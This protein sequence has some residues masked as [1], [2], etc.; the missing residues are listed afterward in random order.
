M[1]KKKSQTGKSK[2]SNSKGKGDPY[3]I[4]PPHTQQELDA[5]DGAIGDD[6]LQDPIIIDTEGNIIDGYARRDICEER[7]IDWLAGA[8]VRVGLSHEQKLAMAIRLN[9]ARRS[10]AP[11]S[12][13][14]REYATA[15]LL[16]NAESSDS[17]IAAVIGLSRQSVQRLRSQLAKTGKL[18]PPLKTVGR[19]G[20][21]R[22]VSSEKR[23]ARFMVKSKAEYDRLA[24]VAHELQSSPKLTNGIIRRP[25][26]LPALLRREKVLAQVDK[27]RLRPLPPSI[28]I[29]CCD[30]RNLEVKPKSVDLICTD[31]VWGK[32]A[33][34][35]WADLAKLA[36]EWLKPDGMFATFIGNMHK[37]EL[38]QAVS[39]YLHPAWEFCLVFSGTTRNIARSII[40]GWRPIAVY[41]LPDSKPNFHFVKDVLTSNGPEKEYDD[42]Q[43]PLPVVKELIRRL[44]PREGTPL[45]VDPQLGT[46]TS[47]VA[48]R[49]LGVRFIGCDIDPKKI[50]IANYRIAQEGNDKQVG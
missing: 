11:T 49:Q 46:G 15:L 9:L 45:V 20:R 41:S 22:A 37:Y 39:P 30:F 43:Q 36:K 47:A 28:D 34:Q 18:T 13:Q 3:R 24:P 14:R 6:G 8:D 50:K 42:W 40:E 26:R 4:L 1:R 32:S 33:K 27:A 29:H 2:R 16:A 21:T 10:T 44:L 19:D 12:K 31:V 7:G 5:L 25:N 35:D 23:K 38:S 48:C 17:S